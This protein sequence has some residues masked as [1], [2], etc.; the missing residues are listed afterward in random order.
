MRLAVGDILFGDQRT[1]HPFD[2]TSL[3]H[4]KDVV[5]LGAGDDRHRNSIAH[6]A[7]HELHCRVINRTLFGDAS[8]VGGF[9]QPEQFGDLVAGASAV[10]SHCVFDNLAVTAAE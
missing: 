7:V 3:Q 4:G 9:S 5:A 1:E 2:R 10:Q 8:L 6:Q